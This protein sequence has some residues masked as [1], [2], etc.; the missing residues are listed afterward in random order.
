MK[1]PLIL[2]LEDENTSLFSK[3][4]LSIPDLHEEIEKRLEDLKTMDKR[5]KKQL[6]QAKEDVN[7]LKEFILWA[8]V[9]LK[10]LSKKR[11][12]NGILFNDVFD[13]YIKSM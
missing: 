4:Y 13:S 3:Q 12:E 1:K 2:S 7:F 11:T 8:L 9:E 5:K 10:Q 6:M